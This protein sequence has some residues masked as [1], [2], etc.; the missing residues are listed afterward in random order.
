MRF[1]DDSTGSRMILNASVLVAIELF[2]A[3]EK[4]LR[5]QVSHETVG[6]ALGI[7]NHLVG[8]V[9]AG[10]MRVTMEDVSHWIAHFALRKHY[11]SLAGHTSND[12]TGLVVK[13]L[14]LLIRAG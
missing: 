7:P 1:A 11:P 9:K 3:T 14:E 6:Q 4:L 10:K 13:S 2:E 12:A 5:A 8:D